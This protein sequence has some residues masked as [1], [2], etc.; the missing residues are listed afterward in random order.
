MQSYI[1]DANDPEQVVA[2]RRRVVDAIM[3]PPQNVGQGLAAMG[4]AFA[5]RRQAQNPFPKAPG[6]KPFT[7]LGRLM[8]MFGNHGLY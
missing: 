3:N 5:D 2:R 7:G 4:Q 1:Y 8:G 6:N